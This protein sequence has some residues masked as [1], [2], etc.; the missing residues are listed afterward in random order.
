MEYALLSQRGWSCSDNTP[1][2]KLLYFYSKY[3]KEREL[4]AQQAMLEQS[5]RRF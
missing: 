2:M 4:A 1:A 3:R 5:R